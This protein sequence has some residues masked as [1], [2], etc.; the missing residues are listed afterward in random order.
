MTEHG[1]GE[2]AMFRCWSQDWPV[3]TSFLPLLAAKTWL[4][5]AGAS[6]WCSSHHFCALCSNANLTMNLH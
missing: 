5:C 2:V 4:V 6:W 1:D 3:P